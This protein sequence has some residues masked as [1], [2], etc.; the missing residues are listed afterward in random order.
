VPKGRPVQHER[1]GQFTHS[2]RSISL[3]VEF[4]RAARARERS[5]RG[6]SKHGWTLGGATQLSDTL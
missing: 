3:P 1:L 6:R 4:L 5:G 2:G